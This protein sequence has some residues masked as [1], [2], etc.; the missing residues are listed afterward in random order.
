MVNISMDTNI[1][2]LRLKIIKESVSEMGSDTD[3]IFSKSL[4]IKI[5]IH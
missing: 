1:I 2:Q 4:M 5:R 3:T